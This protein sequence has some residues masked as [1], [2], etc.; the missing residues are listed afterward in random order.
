MGLRCLQLEALH[1]DIKPYVRNSF[2]PSF[3][4]S[5]NLGN[6]GICIKTIF[7]LILL[8][9]VKYFSTRCCF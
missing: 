2:S 3:I 9:S 4:M 1:Q 8:F 5:V 6:T 7:R